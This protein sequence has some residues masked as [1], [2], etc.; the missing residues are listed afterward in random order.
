MKSDLVARYAKPVPRYTSYPTAP[1]FRPEVGADVYGHWLDAVPDAAGISLY[2]HIPFCDRLC[3]FCGC[4]T[5]QV[6]RYAPIAAYLAS[7]RMEI[8][9]VASRLQGRGTVSAIH[10]GG[11]SPSMLLPADLVDLGRLLRSRFAVSSAAEISIE[12]DPN[13]MDEARY[14]GL[15]EFGITRVSLGVQDFDP[16]VQAAINRIQTLE[17]TAAVVDAVRLRGVRS[18]NLD[19]LYGLPYQS[20]DSVETTVRQALELSPDRLAIFGYAHVPWMKTHQKMIDE[21]AL[22]GTQSRFEQAR[23]AAA[24]ILA[25]GYDAI[26]I[27]HFAKPEDAL[28]VAA[29]AGRL[30]RNFQGY[31]TDD[32][33]TL[34]GLGASAIGQLPQGYVQN[35]VP[36]GEYRKL[37]DAGML[38]TARGIRFSEEDRAR[39]Y[40][41]ERLMC[42]FAVRKSDLQQRFPSQ[43]ATLVRAMETAVILDA[44]GAI[45]FVGDVFAL[46]PSGRPFVRS[47][48]AAFDAYLELGGGHYSAAV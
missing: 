11:G 28:A 44:D 38:A 29:R 33:A 15:A 46:T 32:A 17:Q 7:I 41:I 31:T 20:I 2:L 43:A 13:D 18:L 8:E 1:Q 6:L 22:P 23:A 40:L 48:A 12:L 37:V 42:D 47:V 36:T 30:R 35:R 34:I 26:G 27:D 21:T 5:K 19:V 16:R 24:S 9:T 45:E 3:W 10:L 39:G 4:H 14:D 25:S